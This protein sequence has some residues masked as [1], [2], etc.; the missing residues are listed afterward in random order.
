M[1][2]K[3]L[4]DAVKACEEDWSCPSEACQDVENEEFNCNKC[5]LEQ[6]NKYEFNLLVAFADHIVRDYPEIIPKGGNETVWKRLVRAAEL[7]VERRK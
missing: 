1:T 6:V 7:F 4:V 3:E 2:K 5:A